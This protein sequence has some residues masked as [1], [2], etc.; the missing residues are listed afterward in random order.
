M[1]HYVSLDQLPAGAQAVARQLC[2]G[3]EFASRL[4]AMGL[5]VGSSLDVLQNS[6]H[7]PM[8]VRVHDTRI[9]LG[10]NEAMKIVVEEINA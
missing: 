1:G 5:A 2:G 9:A 3:R 4:G 8:L 6:G 7:G 10:R